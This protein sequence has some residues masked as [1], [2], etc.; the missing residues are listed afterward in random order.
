M[1][2]SKKQYVLSVEGKVEADAAFEAERKRVAKETIDPAVP[3]VEEAEVCM[4]LYTYLNI[5]LARIF[6]DILCR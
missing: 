6:M 5:W 4:H 1:L 3:V 2:Q